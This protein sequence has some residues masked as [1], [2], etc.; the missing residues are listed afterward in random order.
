MMLFM[1]T[2]TGPPGTQLHTVTVG[3]PWNLGPRRIAKFVPLL[4][5]LPQPEWVQATFRPRLEQ[6]AS[7]TE[8]M[9]IQAN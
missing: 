4:S 1:A 8:G 3:H 5:G 6:R 9:A 2:A 7:S